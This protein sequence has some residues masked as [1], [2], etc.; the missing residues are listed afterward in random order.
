[1]DERSV[2]ARLIEALTEE[3]VVHLLDTAFRLWGKTRMK[4]LISAVDEDVASTLSGLLDPER[5]PRERIVSDSRIMQ[6]WGE[7]WGQWGKVAF[8]LGDEEGEY[9]YQEHHWEEPYFDAYSFFADLDKVA[10][11]M[12]PMLKDIHEIGEEDDDV[13]E[14]ALVDIET[15]IG[16]YPEWMGADQ[17]G[18]SLGASATRCVLE[19]ERLAA[20]SAQDFVEKV[21]ALE[22]RLKIVELNG[23]VTVDFFRSLSEEDQRQVLV[24]IDGHRHEPFWQ[25]EIESSH[26]KWHKI[27]HGFR[28]S[29]DPEGHLEDCRGL[30]SQ[31]WRYGLPLIRHL[32]S[33]GESSEAE[34]IVEQTVASFLK[35]AWEPEKALLVS[36]LKSGN[37]RGADHAEVVSLLNDWISVAEKLNKEERAASLRFQ[38]AVYENPLHWDTAARCYRDFNRPPFIR[39]ATRL[40][41]QWKD[42]VLH[43][44]FGWGAAS[45]KMVDECW[46]RWLLEVSLDEAPDGARFISKASDWLGSLLAAPAAEIKGQKNLLSMLTCDLMHFHEPAAKYHCLREVIC[47]SWDGSEEPA[48]SRRDFLKR[49]GGDQLTPLVIQCWK[50]HMAHLMPDPARAE[51]SVYTLHARWLAAL[52][53]LDPQAYRKLINQWKESHKRRT[54]LWKAIREHRLPV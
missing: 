17:D 13:F 33:A 43:A 10:E 42:H 47:G 26:S 46:V 32:A 14:G 3:Q 35:V 25:E 4:E 15:G 45:D 5:A 8:E 36:I 54:N 34:S 39:S 41:E 9:A 16:G 22:N 1:M 50:S 51:K 48:A 27:F 21:A 6:E 11:K 29:F 44:Q 19:W 18:C 7:L 49:V 12:L 28:A 2:G 38:L 40:I 20:G 23:E 37:F 52:N 53:E 31:D 30:L 24:Y